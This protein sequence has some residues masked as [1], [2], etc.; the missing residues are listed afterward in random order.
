M[1]LAYCRDFYALDRVAAA[2]AA[3]VSGVRVSVD[4]ASTQTDSRLSSFASPLS[5]SRASCSFNV[6]IQRF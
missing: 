6:A 4:V 2:S 1:S 3:A 5:V